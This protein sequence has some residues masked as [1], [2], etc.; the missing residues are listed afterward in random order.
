[1]KHPHLVPSAILTLGAAFLPF[2][3]HAA[4]A[5]TGGHGDIGAAYEGPNDLHL[6]L[7]LGEGEAAIVDGSSVDDTEY[8]TDQIHITVPATAEVVLASNA[9][10]LGATAGQSIWFLPSTSQTSSAAIGAPYV[11]WGTEELDPADWVGNISFTLDSVVAPGGS[12]NFAVWQVDG[13]GS[14]SNLA[15][16]TADPGADA[17]VQAAGVHNHYNIGFTKTGLWE[18]TM[19][20]SGTHVA[21][22]FVSDTQTVFFNVVPEPST[23]LLGG[24]GLLAMFRRRR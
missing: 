9:A 2:S 19:T 12:G 3:S 24:F 17:V 18:I 14:L 7:H 23:A 16:S 8:D 4:L 22:G 20:V 11:G 13:F 21:D 5:W 6:H 1:M 10:F 15:M